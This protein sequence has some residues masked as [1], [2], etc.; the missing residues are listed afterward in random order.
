M[1]IL[2]QIVQQ[3]VQKSFRSEYFQ[4]PLVIIV[5]KLEFLQ[6]YLIF[7]HIFCTISGCLIPEG[8]IPLDVV[9]GNGKASSLVSLHFLLKVRRK[10]MAFLFGKLEVISDAELRAALDFGSEKVVNEELYFLL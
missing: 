7:G 8:V 1:H 6:F 3:G 10:I 5:V 9:Y 4:L 2:K